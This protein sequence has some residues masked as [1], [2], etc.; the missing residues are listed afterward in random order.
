MC[1]L[2]VLVWD[3]Y[4][5]PSI[6]L[7]LGFG[8]SHWD[9]KTRPVIGG[10]VGP[11]FACILSD[12]FLRLKRGDRFWYKYR[13][14]PNPFTRDQLRAIHKASMARVLCDN[15]P[16]IDSTQRWPLNLPSSFNPIISCNAT[17]EFPKLDLSFW[18][19]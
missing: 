7:C 15:H 19:E 14:S 18:K 10:Q 9:W 13:D 17:H 2:K 11:T 12:Q 8:K 16:S 1:G 3:V 5:T 6:F 4:T